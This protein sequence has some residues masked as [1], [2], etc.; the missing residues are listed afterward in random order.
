MPGGILFTT[1]RAPISV[2]FSVT[3]LNN[4]I[5][6]NIT[7]VA[8]FQLDRMGGIP[9]TFVV[10]LNCWIF[11]TFLGV[12]YTAVPDS[13]VIRS[14]SGFVGGIFAKTAFAWTWTNDTRYQLVPVDNSAVD[15]SAPQ[16]LNFIEGEGMFIFPGAQPA[17]LGDGTMVIVIE[18]IRLA[19]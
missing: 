1:R 13:F 4:D 2:G 10:P 3:T 5:I 8:G 11:T 15:A 17:G 19:A 7:P 16:Q 18:F 12:P 9:N 14:P 6:P